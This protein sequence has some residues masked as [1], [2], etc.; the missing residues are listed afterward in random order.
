MYKNTKETFQSSLYS[1]QNSTSVLFSLYS[2]M[3][4]LWLIGCPDDYWACILPSVGP[5]LLDFSCTPV[6]VAP[7]RFL[8]LSCDQ[9][10]FS[11]GR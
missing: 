9:T 4:K 7:W 5:A 6:G 8:P 10:A 3:E 11:C 2:Q 1:G